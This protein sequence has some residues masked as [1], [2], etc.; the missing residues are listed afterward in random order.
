MWA[1]ILG[2]KQSLIHR[3]YSMQTTGVDAGR[4]HGCKQWLTS[5]GS[6]DC[7]RAIA[8]NGAARHQAASRQ[9]IGMMHGAPVE[10]PT[11]RCIFTCFP[12]TS[13]RIHCPGACLSQQFASAATTLCSPNKLKLFFPPLLSHVVSLKA[14]VSKV[15]VM[16]CHS[17]VRAF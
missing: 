11:C 10:E 6:Q 4:S 15:S 17:S 3:Q 16:F 2:D 12:K 9:W 14:K 8:K 1:A 13:P 5:S 7:W